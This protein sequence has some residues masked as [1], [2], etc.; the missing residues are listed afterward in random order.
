MNALALLNNFERE[1]AKPFFAKPF[2]NDWRYDAQNDWQYVIPSTFSS[3]MTFDEKTSAWIFTVE[4]AGVT[5][6]NLK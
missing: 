2:K 6:D 3:E 1:F 4:L 5:K